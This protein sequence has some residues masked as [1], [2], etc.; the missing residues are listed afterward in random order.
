MPVMLLDGVYVLLCMCVYHHSASFIQCTFTFKH[1][2][3]L[4]ISNRHSE[5]VWASA[6]S[7]V[8]CFYLY[9][10]LNI[11]WNN[12]SKKQKIQ[13]CTRMKHLHLL[14][15]RNYT[16]FCCWFCWLLPDRSKIISLWFFTMVSNV[17]GFH[18]WEDDVICVCLCH[19]YTFGTFWCW[20][21]F[22]CCTD[23]KAIYH[24]MHFI[25]RT[26]KHS[27]LVEHCE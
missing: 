7:Y 2:C 19:W 4:T 12:K 26:I 25:I 27:I 14:C 22:E 9:I 23:L 11:P 6:Y 16:I 8:S 3:I 17:N 20:F 21:A 24:S 10:Q 18:Q 15:K 1:N 5:I 13:I